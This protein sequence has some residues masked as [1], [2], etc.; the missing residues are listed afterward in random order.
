MSTVLLRDEGLILGHQGRPLLQ[1][2]DQSYEMGQRWVVVGANGAGKSTF[3]RSVLEEELRIAGHRQVFVRPS[4]IAFLPQ[5]P[6]FA[7][8]MPCTIEDFL[9]GSLG[10]LLRPWQ[11]I[12]LEHLRRVEEV[13][14][15]TGLEGKNRNL[16]SVLS[17]GQ[18]Q[19]LLL[20]RALL[21][22]A[23]LYLLDEPFS[24]VQGDS[25]EA[26]VDLLNECLPQSLQIFAL[27]E[28][29]EI[30]IVGGRLI[31]VQ[32]GGTNVGISG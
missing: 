22:G 12:S 15:R 20:A 9:M 8:Q 19:R 24:A 26:L 6:R 17:G 25:K 5:A 32:E 31:Q 14:V 1:V 2:K 16:I 21:M 4:Q 27:H 3:L 30:Q 13:L 10:L 7:H 23:R 29:S 11:A 28:P 18:V